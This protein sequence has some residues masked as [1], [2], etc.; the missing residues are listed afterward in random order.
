M[1]AQIEIKEMPEMKAV[2]CRHIGPFHLISQAY[3]K[4]AQWAVPRGLYTPN[5][6]K[7]ATVTHDDP[8]VTDL[9][10]VRQSACIIVN[11][12]VKVEGEIG[13]LT[14]PWRKVRRRTF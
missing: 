13:K 9:D 12:D 14:T 6:T 4:L 11:E 5:V 8:S 3:E 10:K 2:Y 7:T 1:E